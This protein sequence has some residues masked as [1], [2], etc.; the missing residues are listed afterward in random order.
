MKRLGFLGAAILLVN[1]SVFANTEEQSVANVAQIIEK[2]GLP[3]LSYQARNLAQKALNESHAPLG[4]QLEVVEAIAPLWGP[5]PLQQQWQDYLEEYTQEQ[6]D[7]LLELLESPSLLRARDKEQQAINKQD[8]VEYQQY[9]ARLHRDPPPTSRYQL[10]QELD[11]SMRFSSIL[12]ITRQGVYAQL[13]PLLPKWQSPE[14]WQQRLEKDSVDFLFY[15]HRST[16]N[17][18]LQ[19][20][21]E[22]YQTPLLQSWLRFAEQQLPQVKKSVAMAK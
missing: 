19:H 1:S 12:K 16:S 6:R 22:V 15:V 11:R 2:S 7:E 14:N 20:L 21:I 5:Q 4:L 9:L 3:G 13:K 10:I 8:S 17:M 18:E